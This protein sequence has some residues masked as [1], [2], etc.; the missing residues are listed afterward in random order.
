MNFIKLQKKYLPAIIVVSA[1][2]LSGCASTGQTGD[3][4][5]MFSPPNRENISAQPITIFVPNDKN[6]HDGYGV[7]I[8]RDIHLNTWSRMVIQGGLYYRLL[9]KN[10]SG[11]SFQVESRTDNGAAGSGIIYTINYT[12]KQ[13]PDGYDVI[14]TPTEKETYQ[15]GL[16]GKFS[17]PNFSLY[18]LTEYLTSGQLYYEFDVNS[19]YNPDSVYANFVRLVKTQD[20]G[21]G[22]RDPI[23]GK[24]FKN[25]FVSSVD[26]KSFRYALQ[27][28][29]YHD[30]TKVVI[31]ASVPAIKNKNGVYDYSEAIKK[32]R[33]QVTDVANN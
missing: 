3:L 16:F 26:G 19:K 18:D 11:R 10:N 7:P 5:D 21:S 24:I 15:Q 9:I 25:W 32:I 12:I 8:V 14:F 17:I 23:T 20:H 33:E 28:Y 29:P 31:Y 30:G 6:I 27:T 4:P 13:L 1:S 2:M 22:E